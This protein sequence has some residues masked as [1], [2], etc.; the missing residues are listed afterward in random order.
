MMRVGH[1]YD[2]HRLV[3]GG[4]HLMLG[5]VRIPHHQYLKAHSDGDVLIH[6]VIDALLGAAALGDIGQ[7]FPDSDQR[8]ADINSRRLLA[9][10]GNA[11]QERQVMINNLD[12]T[13]VAQSPKL[14]PYITQMKANLA[15]DLQLSV[16]QVNI[17]A[18]TTEGLGF[19]G[20]KQGIAVHAVSL[21][22][23]L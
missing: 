19:V 9:I 15:E 10:V 16:T 13:V 7:W 1:G 21:V 12:V 8:Y 2:V 11:L 20:T 22:D 17:K 6:A 4:S 14:Q 5:G 18:T 23:M 3:D